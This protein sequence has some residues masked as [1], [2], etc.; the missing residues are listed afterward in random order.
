MR[1][2]AIG[3]LSVATLVPSIVGVAVPRGKPAN[4]PIS[5]DYCAFPLK[6]DEMKNRG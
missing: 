1:A 3:L 5:L 4:C 2:Q 6:D